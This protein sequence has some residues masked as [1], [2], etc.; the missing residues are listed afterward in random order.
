MFIVCAHVCVYDSARKCIIIRKIIVNSMKTKKKKRKA[1][2]KSKSGNLT[3]AEPHVVYFSFLSF[4]AYLS[5]AFHHRWLYT[6]FSQ[7]H[8]AHTDKL[9]FHFH[10]SEIAIKMAT[11]KKYIK[12]DPFHIHNWKQQQYQQC[13]S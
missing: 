9:T 6:F 13:S 11:K 4:Q 2:K 12:F 10:Q 5:L 1:K 7:F 3:Q 8:V